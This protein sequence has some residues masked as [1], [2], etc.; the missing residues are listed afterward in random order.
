ME[1]LLVTGVADSAAAGKCQLKNLQQLEMVIVKM[2]RGVIH[3]KLFPSHGWTALV[4]K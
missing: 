4:K 3:Y 1:V 2:A